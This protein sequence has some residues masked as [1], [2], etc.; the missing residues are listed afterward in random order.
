MGLPMLSEPVRC[1]GRASAARGSLDE[2]HGDLAARLHTRLRAAGCHEG[3]D[4]IRSVQLQAI[5]VLQRHVGAEYRRLAGSE[6]EGGRRLNEEFVVRPRGDH[7][8]RLINDLKI[9]LLAAGKLKRARTVV[10]VLDREGESGHGRFLLVGEVTRNMHGGTL[11]V[12]GGQH[13]LAG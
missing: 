10:L 13:T 8:A 1:G 5:P 3:A 11:V 7:A 2:Q 6:R 4:L 12:H 9:K